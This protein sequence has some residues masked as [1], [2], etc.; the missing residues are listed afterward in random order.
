MT[1][2]ASIFK[3]LV[4]I[5]FM[6][7]L[8][9][10]VNFYEHDYNWNGDIQVIYVGDHHNYDINFKKKINDIAIEF[11]HQKDSLVKD[12]NTH[13]L[14]DLILQDKYIR[15]AEVYL[16][17]EG[18]AHIYICFRKPFIRFLAEDKVCY[19]D[20]EGIRLP[21]LSNIGDDLIV[22]S[23]DWDQKK[24]DYLFSLV[25]AIYNHSFLNKLIGGIYYDKERGYVLSS[26]ICDLG[27]NLGNW[28]ELNQVTID[29]IKVFYNFL[30]RELD[31][32]YCEFI[33]V[34]Y[35]NQIICIK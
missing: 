21:S 6:G 31:C 23:G 29:M 14:E 32:N 17:L 13:L 22:V 27:I 18:T 35:D 5:L 12:I 30:L 24:N 16:D 9:V 2:Y 7:F 11:F 15:K 19:F 1:N 26:R 20:S 10:V 3:F 4:F 34:Q 25:N 8:F 33:D 28:Q